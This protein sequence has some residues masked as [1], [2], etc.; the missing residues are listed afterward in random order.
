MFG[1]L[2]GQFCFFMQKI[3]KKTKIPTENGD[4]GNRSYRR[5]E[6]LIL[7]VKTQ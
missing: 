6:K 1:K 3:G 4:G 7:S 5:N 2:V